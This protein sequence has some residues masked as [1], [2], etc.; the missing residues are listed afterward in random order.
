MIFRY[1]RNT[2]IEGTVYSGKD[3]HN[4]EIAAFHLSR[5]LELNRA[6]IVS[7]RI[8]N[9]DTEILPVSTYD[10]SRTFYKNGMIFGH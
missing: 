7:G 2:I 3:R 9:L 10:L 6:P 8:L 5:L 4:G 1:E